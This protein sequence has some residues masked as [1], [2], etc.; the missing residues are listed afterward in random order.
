MGCDR[1]DC[2]YR[3]EEKTENCGIGTGSKYCP[4]F[5]GS[6]LNAKIVPVTNAHREDGLVILLKDA[7]TQRDW[8]NDKL[9]EEDL[10]GQTREYYGGSRDA[11]AYMATAI[12]EAIGS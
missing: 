2:D 12:Q 6:S 5:I 9:K 7:E 11:Y 1:L 3:D 10:K 4:E 8:F